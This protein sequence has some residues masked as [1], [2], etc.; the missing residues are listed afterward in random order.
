MADLLVLTPMRFEASAARRGADTAIVKRSGI[1][2][3]RSRRSRSE[4]AAQWPAGP[5]AV[6]GLCGGLQGHLSPG[7]II[8]ATEVRSKDGS[9]GVAMPGADLVAA[10]LASQGLPVHAGPIVTSDRVASGRKRSKLAATGALGVDMESAW[11]V[12]AQNGR[13]AAPGCVVRVVSDAPGHELWSWRTPR[14]AIRARRRLTQIVPSLERWARAAGSHHVV[15]AGPRSFCAGVDRAI[16]VVERALDK[17][18]PPI[19]V[20]RQI[21][22]NTHVVRDLEERGAV[23]VQEV[24][25]VP[26][27]SRLIL[28]AHGVSPAVRRAADARDL[29]VIDA[30]CPLVAKVHSEARRFANDGYDIVLIGHDDHEEVEGTIGE[31]PGK[32]SVVATESDVDDLELNNPDRV[33]YLTQT[34]LAVNETQGVVD[35]LQ[36]RFPA[37]VGPNSDDIC[38]ATQNRQEAV[39]A[40]AAECDLILVVGSTNSSNSNRLVEVAEVAGC[41]SHLIDDAGD[42][43]LEWL[44]GVTTV[45]VTAGASAPESKVREVVAAIESLGPVVVE[46]RTVHE[47]SVTFRLPAE[48]R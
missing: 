45:G 37:L 34:T 47:E 26:P 32:V 23:F 27:G 20:R 25:D 41:Q 30:T 44:D 40:M 11:L 12:D 13:S 14:N 1:G 9:V 6:L 5:V 46:E 7:D 18:E 17:F 28:A 42:I 43:R 2:P 24:D 35:R 31:A 29:N 22:H 10:E 48:V 4:L 15:L 19:F 3:T 33:A 38:Y 8:V 21:I 36:S 39:I 16:E